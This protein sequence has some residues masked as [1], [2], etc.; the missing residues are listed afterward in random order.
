V[1]YSSPALPGRR[2]DFW[3]PGEE[4]PRS[5]AKWS[6]PLETKFLRFETRQ[7][8]DSVLSQPSAPAVK[9]AVPRPT[10]ATP[11]TWPVPT[12]PANASDGRARPECPCWRLLAPPKD[13]Q[14]HRGTATA[15][16]GFHRPASVFFF[17]RGRGSE[18]RCFCCGGPL[19]VLPG[20]GLLPVCWRHWAELLEPFR[21]A[22][23][24]RG[25]PG[26]PDPVEF[27]GGHRTGQPGI[28]GPS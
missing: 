26:L 22:R 23:S 21:C 3:D 10:T 7:E 4:G 17:C 1:H 16:T 20:W 8:Q 2:P 24:T 18:N 13:D 28:S 11:P 5:A 12:L 27:K 14:A 19:R 15:A 9:S 25:I 6:A